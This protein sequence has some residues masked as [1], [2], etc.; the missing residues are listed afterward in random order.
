MK[1]KTRKQLMAMY[2][3][4]GPFR[5]GLARVIKGDKEFHIRRDGTAAY[6][7]RF[8]YV[9]SFNRGNPALALADNG[10]PGSFFHIQRNGKRV[11]NR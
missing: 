8:S 2:D 11:K 7:Q 4:V 3:E 9:G 1:V 6:R 10:K 5:G